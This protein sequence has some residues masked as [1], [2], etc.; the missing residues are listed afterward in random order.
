MAFQIPK[1]DLIGIIEIKNLSD[2]S[3]EELIN[4]LEL[5]PSIRDSEEMAKHI[6]ADVPLIPYE[7]LSNILYTMDTLYHVREFSGVEL[8]TFVDDIIQW[9]EES[10]YPDLKLEEWKE[11]EFSSLR[12]RLEKLLG[13]KLLRFIS[14]ATRIQ[15]DGER[16]YCESKILSDIRPVFHADPS[17]LPSSAVIT[18]TLKIIYHTGRGREEVHIVLDS[19]SLESLRNVINRAYEKDE[20]LKEL[21]KSAHL[22]NLGA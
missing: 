19:N 2:E 13:I 1:N 17:V 7:E 4:A 16:L 5:A 11:D 15:R 20:T 10:P 21:M 22:E 6:A 18:H 8:S 9:M 3:I 14:K 12:A